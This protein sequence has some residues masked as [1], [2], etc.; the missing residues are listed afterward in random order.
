MN[1]G[2][3]S[4][5]EKH[6]LTCFWKENFGVECIGCGM[7]RSFILLLKGE[8]INAFYMYPAIYSLLFL[9]GYTFLYILFNFQKG[10][11][12]IL[13]LF[14]INIIIMLGNFIIKTFNY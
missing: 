2:I 1:M 14:I 4:Y 8:F 10:H 11:K 3:I 7:Q 5:L 9:F 12:I 13:Y 6:M